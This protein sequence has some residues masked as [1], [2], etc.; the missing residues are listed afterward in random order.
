MLKNL[1]KNGY[2]TYIY[3]FFKIKCWHYT[4]SHKVAIFKCGILEYDVFVIRLPLGY[5]SW[6]AIREVRLFIM[7]EITL[8]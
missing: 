4:S 6:W 2:I 7:Y 1:I 5:I 8:W 3:L